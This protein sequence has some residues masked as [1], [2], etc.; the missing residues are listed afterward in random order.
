M[1]PP[2]KI[3]IRTN[4]KGRAVYARRDI[5]R[6]EIIEI[7]PAIIVGHDPRV[8]VDVA[9][10]KEWAYHFDGKAAIALGYGSLYNHAL[11]P[12]A[13]WRLRKVAG[14]RFIVIYARKK[15]AT[16]Q[17]ICI[18]YCDT[19]GKPCDLAFEVLT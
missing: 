18:H 5:R 3:S 10:Y 11:H 4:T 19:P 17:E 16:G 8:S 6:G 13:S 7:C 2:S 14:Q 15:I 1:L 12:N 9:P